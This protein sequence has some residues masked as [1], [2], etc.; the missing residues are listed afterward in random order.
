MS[1]EIPLSF[2]SFLCSTKFAKPRP[3]KTSTDSR[4][5]VIVI[6]EWGLPIV[7]RYMGFI[8][9]NA[10]QA[11]RS[12]LKRTVEKLGRSTLHAIDYMDE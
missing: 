8:T 10:E 4:S 7:Q 2:L 11:V 9:D 12:L 6:E 5:Y 1:I 3:H